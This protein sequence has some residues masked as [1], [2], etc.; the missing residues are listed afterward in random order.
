MRS[1]SQLDGTFKH[2]GTKESFMKGISMFMR[3]PPTT[4]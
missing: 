2:V 3:A 4:V 1:S